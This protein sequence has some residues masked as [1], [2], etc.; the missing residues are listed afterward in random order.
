MH[1]SYASSLE[2][3]S[4]TTIAMSCSPKEEF[5]CNNGYCLDKE[6]VCDGEDD[7]EDGEDETDCYGECLVL[8]MF[9]AQ[10]IILS[11]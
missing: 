3:L 11:S 2:T 10:F 4:D 1:T 5:A 7:C 9:G 8:T 6:W